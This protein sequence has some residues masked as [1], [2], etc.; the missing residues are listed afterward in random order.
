MSNCIVAPQPEA[1]EAGALVL[2]KGGNAV[3]AAITA[4]LVQG[5]IDP[6]MCGLGGYALLN[7]HWAGNA[8]SVGIDAPALAGAGVSAAMW[9]DK[10]LRPSPGGW[11]FF[12]EGQLNEAGYT[13]ICTPGAVKMYDAMLQRWGSLSWEE[14]IQPAVALAE[15]GF[16][17]GAHAANR[18]KEPPDYPDTC[19]L[20]DYI[21][22]N[23]EARRIYLRADGQPYDVGQTIRNPDAA[24]TLRHLARNGAD[25]FYYGALMEQMT[26]DLAAN[27][28]FVTRQDFENY[29]L[30]ENASVEGTYRGYPLSS[31]APPHGGPTLL[32]ILNILEGYDLAAMGHNSPDY[33][34]TVAMAMKAAFAD[35]NQRMADAAFVD[36]PVAWMISKSRAAEWREVIDAGGPIHAGFGPAEKP[37]TTQVT[38]VDA[39]GNCVS[40][41][42]SLGSSSGVITPGLGFMYNN[43]MV[44]FHPWAGHA[45]SIAPGKGRT[46]GMAPTIVYQRGDD[47]MRHPRLVLGAAGCHPHHHVDLAGDPQCAGF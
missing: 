43:S 33:I 22:R 30:Q 40:L 15:E 12:L 29:Q 24:K 18:W 36:V 9:E 32:A 16:V 28:S 47:A 25:D 46:T 44:N 8:G 20:L 1:V 7:L 10:V 37:H 11:G 41:T 23:P 3:D 42:H 27:A 19:S 35:R 45:N 34:Y 17:V 38:V 31:A 13:S 6:Q 21:L 2:R 26:A 14:A 5:V 39:A 4:A